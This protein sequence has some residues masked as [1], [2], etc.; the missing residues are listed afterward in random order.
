MEKAIF[1]KDF[2]TFAQLTMRDS[3][4]FHSVCLD[5]YPPVFYLND[6]SKQII[7]VISAY[8]RFVAPLG[9]GLQVAYT[10]DAGPNAVLFLQKEHVPT[11]LKVL[12]HFFPPPTGP[13]AGEYFGRAQEFLSADVQVDDV[14]K[15]IKVP[16]CPPGTLKRIISTHVGDGP[17]VLASTYDPAVSLLNM[18]GLPVSLV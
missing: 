3:N 9:K 6:T 5:T 4:Q 17:R 7:S 10:F 15:E 13:E 12:N 11:V 8:N 16:V 2:D 18:D 14:L 1:E